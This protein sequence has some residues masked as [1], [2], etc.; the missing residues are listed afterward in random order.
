MNSTNKPMAAS[1]SG[2]RLLKAVLFLLIF[3]LGFIMGMISMATFPNFYGPPL[4]LSPM[5]LS[6]LAPSSTAMLTTPS[7]ST[8]T[9]SPTPSA[10]PPPTE[11]PAAPMGLTA[12]LA[13]SGVMHTMTDEELLWRASMAPKVSHTPYSFVP[14]VAFLFLVRNQLPLRPLWEKFF[15]G[16]KHELYSIYVHSYPPFAASLPT[17][18]VF[19]GSMIP[20]QKTSWG[21][22]NLVE[23]ERR[24][25]ANALLDLSNERFALLS[26]SCIPIYDFPTVYAH[27]TGSNDS[28]VDCFDNAGARVRY[29]PDVFARHNITQAQWRKGSQWFEMDRALAVEVVSDEAYFPAFRDCRRCVIDEH[30]I[31]TL[32]N[33]LGWRRNANRT[34][35]YM[36]W[37]P[38]SPHPR[39]HGA[40]DVTEELFR[41]MRSGAANC[42]YNGAASNICFVFA[43]KF[44]PDAL[45]PLLDLAPKVMGFG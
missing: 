45:G 23:A 6:S 4:L 13:P 37:P 35:T 42:T 38:R 27:L 18:S 8:E 24:L 32:V 19:Y 21:D 1:H 26:E 31:P 10:S 43:R 11:R 9:P 25:L 30:Y 39:V 41:K 22:A 3:S 17:D 40:V 5:L 44:S 28:F 14:K 2:S 12:F 33:T 34:L 36:E 16:H 20:S 15:A 7:P 29:R